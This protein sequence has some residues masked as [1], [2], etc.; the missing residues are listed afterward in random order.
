MKNRYRFPVILC[1]LL[2]L[3]SGI[4]HSQAPLILF[5]TDFG[6]D[7]DDLGS[8]AML[9]NLEN[10][11][12][13]ELLGIMCWNTEKSAIPA[14][15]AV[16]RH[17]GNEEIPVGVRKEGSR[18]IDWNYSKSISDKLPHTLTQEQAEDASYYT[19]KYW[20][21]PRIIALCC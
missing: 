6:G 10:R 9:H 18:E 8:L 4:L 7:S 11:G 17:Y 13:C 3:L 1:S 16:N 19:G 5:D 12:E 21:R 2:L 15:D 14:I 20:N